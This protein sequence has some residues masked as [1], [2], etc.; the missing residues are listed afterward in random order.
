MSEVASSAVSADEWA[1]RRRTHARA[2]AQWRRY[3]V[4]LS[5]VVLAVLGFVGWTWEH[6]EI[7]HVR[8]N[9]T[10]IA[11]VA[12]PGGQLP[13]TLTPAWHTSDRAALGDAV[14]LDVVVTFGGHTVTG[15]DARTGA[16][17]WTYT[18]TDRKLCTA[19]VQ[20]DTVMAVY[21]HDGICD[22]ATGLD[23]AS[24]KRVWTRTLL[25]GQPVQAAAG[26]D[27]Y[28]F[29]RPDIVYT[30]RSYH[31]EP[32]DEFDFTEPAGCVTRAA[33]EGSG[34]V[35]ISNRCTSAETLTFFA[36][37]AAN[38]KWEQIWQVPLAGR[39]PL[40]AD[41]QLVVLARN[42][43]TLQVLSV[44]KGTATNTLTLPHAAQPPSTPASIEL[45][46]S[47]TQL[48]NVAGA[49][50]AISTNGT[51][52]VIWQRAAGTLSNTRAGVYTTKAGALYSVAPKTGLERRIATASGLPANARVAIVGRGLLSDTATGVTVYR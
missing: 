22:E 40:S 26:Q 29:I 24:G 43:R 32:T 27:H 19:L 36:Y 2:V 12:L 13:A 15:R 11:A 21:A 47:E 25:G 23:D 49:T 8:S 9:P 52:A 42:G 14:D 10:A 1:R 20:D 3:A 17:R 44:K 45:P 50:V 4:G 31:P 28:L 5:V 7:R 33:V 16:A 6:G 39:T 46:D 35:L 51:P 37:V 18:R 41:G 30:V 48:I 34:G 38:L